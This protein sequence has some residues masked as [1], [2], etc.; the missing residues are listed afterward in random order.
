[1]LRQLTLIC[2]TAS[3]AHML[4]VSPVDIPACT[5]VTVAQS[6]SDST[7]A[8]CCVAAG[9]APADQQHAPASSHCLAG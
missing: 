3:A 4:P 7:A 9:Q 8:C 1:M 2:P 5:P 6:G